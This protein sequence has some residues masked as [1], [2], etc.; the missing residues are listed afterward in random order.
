MLETSKDL[1]PAAP[2][3]LAQGA[4]ERPI[5]LSDEQMTMV[6]Q[7]AAPLQQVDRGPFLEALAVMLRNEPV[8]GDG[9]VARACRLLQSEFMRGRWP[10]DFE[11]GRGA[12]LSC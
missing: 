3:S 2:H 9:T 11:T 7:A 8:L 6:L 5:S 12:R 4:A 1:H 10:T